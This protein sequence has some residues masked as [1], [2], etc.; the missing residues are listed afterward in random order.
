[1]APG[2][3][4]GLMLEQLWENVL[5]GKLS[6]DKESLLQLA[7]SLLKSGEFQA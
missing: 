1:M 7:N 6:S 3:Q 2:P 4:V 5:L